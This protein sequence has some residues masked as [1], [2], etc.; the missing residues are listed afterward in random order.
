[1]GIFSSIGNVLGGFLGPV[2]GLL[3]GAVGGFFDDKSTNNQAKD[4]AVELSAADANLQREFAQQGVRWR[5]DD[6][7]AAGIH[8]LAALGAQLHQ[9]SPV[10][11]GSNPGIQRTDMNDMG[12][13]ISRAIDATATQPER[14]NRELGELALERARLE[15]DILRGQVS[16]VGRATNPAFPGVSNIPSEL[17]ASRPGQ[18][19]MEAAPPSPGVKQF[20]YKAGGTWDLPSEKAKQAI[21]DVFP[22]EVEHYYLNRVWPAIQKYFMDI[23]REFG[24]RGP[25]GGRRRVTWQ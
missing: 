10:F 3:G 20:D 4:Q 21:E 2:G 5:V 6:A 22:Y 17:T 14:V 18:P 23:P 7:K 25:P 15:N 1:M 19:F 11:A 13:N 8:P 24:R 16:L 12:Q 9:A